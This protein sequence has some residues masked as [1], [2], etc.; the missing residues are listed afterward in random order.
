[1]AEDKCAEIRETFYWKD[2]RNI[3][4]N[5]LAILIIVANVFLISVILKSPK[6][7]TQRFNL[8]IISLAVTDML[9]GVLIP[10]N[11]LRVCRWNFG[12]M[13]C[14]II[15]SLVVVALSSSIYNFVFVNLDRLLAVKFPM[16]YKSSASR[17]KIKVGILA[18]WL[19]SSLPALPMW[20]AP[21]SPAAWDGQTCKFPY[22]NEIWVWW[23]S[24]SVFIIPTA[25]ILA[26]WVMMALHF[27]TPNTQHASAEKKARRITLVM[28]TI[29]LAFLI[30][31]WPYAIIF[32]IGDFTLLWNV[33]T[34]AYLNSLINPVLY[35]LINRDVRICIKAILTCKANSELTRAPSVN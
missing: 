26:I 20:V 35:I 14:Q 33:V 16:D 11:T 32:M 28:G 2:P 25:L 23:S 1:M 12:E 19:L 34:L 7:R 8:I 27:R 9:C 22:E 15:T 4:V 6:L 3:F 30:C 24:A 13:F 21:S 18:C 29:T 5:T 10:F 17:K 31:W